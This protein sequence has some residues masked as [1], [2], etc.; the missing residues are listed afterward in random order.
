MS[1]AI[2]CIVEEAV[3]LHDFIAKYD[4]AGYDIKRR[5]LEGWL[6][7][8]T[9]ESICHLIRSKQHLQ[10]DVKLPASFDTDPTERLRGTSDVLQQFDEDSLVI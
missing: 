6:S 3:L 1:Q 10:K 8:K 7:C 2:R 9:S 5:E 4:P